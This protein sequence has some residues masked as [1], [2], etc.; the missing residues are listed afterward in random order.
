M[1][2]MLWTAVVVSLATVVA[3]ADDKPKPAETPAEKLAA[4]QKEAKDAETE[5]YKTLDGLGEDKEAQKKVNELFEKH[6]KEQTKRYEV[7][8]ELAKADPKS[9]VG[10]DAL[11]WLLETP[12]TYYLS[13]GKP[14]MELTLEHHAAN[15]KVGKMILV[16]G[17]F[18]PHEGHE[19]H[20]LATD[21]VRTVGEKNPD[22]TVRGQV[23]VVTAWKA[24]EKFEAAE[25][26]KQKDADELAAVAE[27]AFE[28]VT[29][30]YGECKLLGRKAEQTL[31]DVSK[32][33]LFELRNLRVGK[34]APDIDG[35]DL[36]G[37]KFKLS[38]YKGK[39][40]VLDFWGDW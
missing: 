6:E 21:L 8:I 33:E 40:V 5:L 13:V 34:T 38:D 30:E 36:D 29:K 23:A 28:A 11:A 22:K 3:A 10:F 20:K 26:K 18:G 1:Y 25:Y 31:A 16:L 32:I 24:K 7:A 27:K 39:V 4:I 35:E 17:R 37:V 15:P 14:A 9:D 19:N 2:R 12:R